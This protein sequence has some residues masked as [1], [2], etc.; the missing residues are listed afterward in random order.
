V[1][2]QGDDWSV[3]PTKDGMRVVTARRILDLP[4][5]NLA[6]VH[7]LANAAQAIAT[8]DAMDRP[9]IAAAAVARGVTA[10]EWPG[11]LQRL[12]RGRLVESL[13]TGWELWVDGGHNP[14]AG[15]VVGAQAAAWSDKPLDLVFGIL[16]T[17]DP[18]GF[19]APIAPHVR[20]L[21]ALTI[22]DE[23]ASVP[24]TEAAAIA[25]RA[26]VDTV[27]ADSIEDALARLTEGATPGRILVCGSLYLAGA[28]LA[29]NG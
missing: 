18:D 17:K 9:A 8:L 7:Q 2:R 6:G 1:F 3:A 14:G 5:P 11:R 26:G 24:G 10:A 4:L 28:V 16:N 19:L 21:A 20:R 13:P 29:R 27:V 23:E 25:R 15:A 12:A 22:P